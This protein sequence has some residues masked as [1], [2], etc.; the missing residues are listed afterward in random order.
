MIGT[1]DTISLL[2]ESGLEQLYALAGENLA[3]QELVNN[4]MNKKKDLITTCDRL[5][6]D[7]QNSTE[8]VVNIQRIYS[9]VVTER[10]SL[11]NKNLNLRKA[12]S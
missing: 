4:L 2:F 10:Y 6:I 1:L 5:R 12:L 3:L 9:E 8:L 11:I 7:L